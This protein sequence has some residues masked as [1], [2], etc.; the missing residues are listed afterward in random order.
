MP[1]GQDKPVQSGGEISPFVQQSLAQNKDLANNRLLSAMQE[2]GATSRTVMQEQGAT[3]RT[4]MQIQGQRQTQAA[5][6]EADDRRAAEAEK[7][8]REDMQFTK[9]M[10]ESNQLFQAEQAQLEREYQDASK[11]D[12]REY[13]EKLDK[14]RESLR[15]FEIERNL[16]AQE[17]S[18]NAMLTMIK[19]SMQKE[20]AQE[21]AV[22]VL[23]QEAEKFDKDKTVYER[24]ISRVEESVKLDKRMDLPTPVSIRGRIPS[25]GKVIKDMVTGVPILEG[26]KQYK[27]IKSIK[28]DIRGGVANPMGVLQSQLDEQETGISVEDISPENIHNLESQIQEGKVSPE[29]IR[30]TLAALNGMA[31]QLDKR[32][33]STSE[34]D[35]DFW[36]DSYRDTIRMRDAIER[37]SNST[38]KLSGDEN[39]TVGSI[40]NDSVGV[41]HNSS[42]GG[43]ATR[44]KEIAG[45][46]FS[47]VLEEMTKSL[48]VPALWPTEGLAGYDLEL[49]EKENAMYQRLYPNLGGTD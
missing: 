6:I 28:E 37:L 32:Y 26:Y 5:Q 19:G 8:R 20:T 34:T 48:Q 18:T 29:K 38:K 10:T 3:D 33:T 25:K 2:A 45:G 1:R 22:T 27:N 24:T 44:Y 23:Q 31:N 15:R 4:A 41:I 46:D 30:A 17:R 35:A 9:A 47:A 11:A 39:R 43:L 36:K 7:S 16:T 21:K 40:I 14:R 12:D 13:L 49:R 42:I